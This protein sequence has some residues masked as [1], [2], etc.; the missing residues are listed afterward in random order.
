MTEKG[1]S[2]KITCINASGGLLAAGCENGSV[3]LLGRPGVSCTLYP[4]SFKQGISDPVIAI[5]FLEDEL[6]GQL[7]AVSMVSVSI[8][9]IEERTI[10][11]TI[12]L[13]DLSKKA[14]DLQI[15]CSTWCSSAFGG[16]FVYLGLTTGRVVAVDC[17]QHC[18]SN[19]Q[20][21]PSMFLDEGEAKPYGCVL[22]MEQQP[23]E[24]QNLLLCFRNGAVLTWSLKARKV[25]RRYMVCPASH[26]FVKVATHT[27]NKQFP[28]LPLCAAW[29]PGRGAHLAVG[30][31]NGTVLV[32]KKN[33]PAKPL[34]RLV[35]SQSPSRY[36]ITNLLWDSL[37]SITGE[38][39]IGSLYVTGGHSCLAEG[40][41]EQI[42]GVRRLTGKGLQR[43]SLLAQFPEH[44]KHGLFEYLL[45][46]V[47]EYYETGPAAECELEAMVTPA[48]FTL[49]PSTGGGPCLVT[50]LDANT[51]QICA[52]A[53][54]FRDLGVAHVPL[55]PHSLH[56]TSSACLTSSISA[57]SLLPQ[58][59]ATAPPTSPDSVAGAIWRS[60]RTCK[61]MWADQQWP[62]NAG[63][64]VTMAAAVASSPPAQP[65]PLFL[66]TAHSLDSTLQLWDVT[67]P[68]AV[69]LVKVLD[70][71]EVCQ[72]KVV[73]KWVSFNPATS[74]LAVATANHELLIL[75]AKI[76][77][78]SAAPASSSSSSSSSSS[79]SSSSSSSSSLSSPSSPSSLQSSSEVSTPSYPSTREV[80]PPQQQSQD[81]SSD[82]TPFCSDT[83]PGYG[84][85]HNVKNIN[86]LRYG[87][88][89]SWIP[90]PNAVEGKHFVGL[91]FATH[92]R[93][94]SVSLGRDNTGNFSDRLGSAFI[95]VTTE[96]N[97][98]QHTTN[99]TRLTEVVTIPD[100]Q[101][102]PL[103]GIVAS[104][105]RVVVGADMCLDH[106]LVFGSPASE[107]KDPEHEAV[108]PSSTASS[109]GQDEDEEGLSMSSFLEIEPSATEAPAVET[110]LSPSEAA[111]A[112]SS[113]TGSAPSVSEMSPRGTAN[114]LTQLSVRSESTAD[115][116]L[117]SD[118]SRNVSLG[119]G[120][121]I[122]AE[123]SMSSFC[124][125]DRQIQSPTSTDSNVQPLSTSETASVS[126]QQSPR[127]HSADDEKEKLGAGL[128]PT[129][130]ESKTVEPSPSATIMVR[131]KVAGSAA[132]SFMKFDQHCLLCAWEDGLFTVLV[133]SRTI[134]TRDSLKSVASTGT[135]L[136][137]GDTIHL[138]WGFRDG[139]L[140]FHTI[141]AGKLTSKSIDRCEPG[142][143]KSSPFAKVVGPVLLLAALNK[144]GTRH[145]QQRAPQ[146]LEQLGASPSYMLTVIGNTAVILSLMELMKPRC[147]HLDAAVV[148]QASV[149]VNVKANE[150]LVS[151]C[152]ATHP[153]A[154]LDQASPA[155]NVLVC[156]SNH[157][158]VFVYGLMDLELLLELPGGTLPASATTSRSPMAT[159]VPFEDGRLV[160]LQSPNCLAV[161]SL[162][163]SQLYN[164]PQTSVSLSGFR[165]QQL[166]RSQGEV[167]QLDK[168][169]TL[170]PSKGR[171][172]T[173]FGNKKSLFGTLTNA[174]MGSVMGTV[175]LIDLLAK[176]LAHGEDAPTG[177]EPQD[178]HATRSALFA[179]AEAGPEPAQLATCSTKKPA[180]GASDVSNT[181]N[182]NKQ[183]LLD[184]IEKLSQVEDKS[185]QMAN[186]A[187]DFA[188][189]AKRLN[190]QQARSSKFFGLL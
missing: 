106:L 81:V 64:L 174:V 84:Q 51:G 112:V 92:C 7:V 190:Q 89:V 159:T 36:P 96:A 77:N 164:L 94:E 144:H 34:F 130:T 6:A 97:P 54:R 118:A 52:S 3:Q 168:S 22:A 70:L 78:S 136:V 141:C 131:K 60:V 177:P 30:M 175:P 53:R 183:R 83:I 73:V 109:D 4:V 10:V 71:K 33:H 79:P 115:Q 74:C 107:Y 134:Q 21:A 95:E 32:W 18:L 98:G 29:Q 41:Q 154:V 80:N 178:P 42:A 44:G 176:P 13:E 108:P 179:G 110:A 149:P 35:V 27:D 105:I 75:D 8:W 129:Q 25:H 39:D 103:D 62:L 37:S 40:K 120:G 169:A 28:D 180:G 91:A 93:L 17:L 173:M 184:N 148:T 139:T 114:S 125:E 14:L 67:F 72:E 61:S 182:L 158:A 187:A 20:I 5:Y 146:N 113:S 45:D 132:I 117:L 150:R 157:G 100:A 152:V 171:R 82:A 9:S 122:E 11:A 137:W 86:D 55:E 1:F 99:W 19:Y 181:M 156:V 31:T 68:H 162:F 166:Q 138:I 85:I 172:T 135:V 111:R 69:E 124:E 161:C 58:P 116:D 160:T 126:P 127:S 145:I 153:T 50:V 59:S 104:G 140:L 24:G 170:N 15:Q 12:D 188:A 163:P 87:N 57:L 119:T 65:D 155:P 165:Q 23:G 76:S 185:E 167:S 26:D 43:S 186:H 128:P 46:E 151:A 101:T 133:G 88:D 56:D 143:E 47:F 48:V 147:V 2:S 66:I 123:M 90:G 38:F 121:D 189:A 142:Q 63:S 49:L 16:R 102:F